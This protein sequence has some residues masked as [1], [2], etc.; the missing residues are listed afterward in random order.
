MR[1]VILYAEK[2]S[3]DEF[4]VEVNTGI[5]LYVGIGKRMENEGNLTAMPQEARKDNSRKV[6]PRRP[7]GDKM[8][9]LALKRGERLELRP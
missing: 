6:L 3:F 1:G 8:V 5:S 7:F 2:D 4:V 9:Y